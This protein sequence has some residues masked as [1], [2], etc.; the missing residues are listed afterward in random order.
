MDVVVKRVVV[1]FIVLLLLV[2][3][4]PFEAFSEAIMQF[5][6]AGVLPGVDVAMP[7]TATFLLLTETLLLSLLLIFRRELNANVTQW[8]VARILR[9]EAAA[10]QPAPASEVAPVAAPD[11]IVIIIPGRPGLLPR[12]FKAL[13]VH[14]PGLIRRGFLLLALGCEVAARKFHSMVVAVWAWLQVV[15]NFIWQGLTMLIGVIAAR[16]SRAGIAIWRYASAKVYTY[17]LKALPY[18]Y[19]FDRWL[20]VKFKQN[21]GRIAAAKLVREVKQLVL[22]W[23]QEVS[24]ALQ[25]ISTKG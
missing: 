20:E 3:F 18:L 8:H 15:A 2:N 12:F 10:A 13:A 11:P 1:W 4:L 23:R 14:S 25:R 6:A 9:T 5:V 21:E 7:A 22:N 24:S 17:W 16:V 19:Q